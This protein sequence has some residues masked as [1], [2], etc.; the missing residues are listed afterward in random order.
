MVLSEFGRKS[1][2]RRVTDWLAPLPDSSLFVSVVTLGE[3][4]SGIARQRSVD[5]TFSERLAVW[6]AAMR[7]DFEERTLAV[8][9]AVALRW[10][11][12]MTRLRRRDTDLLIA[13]T[14]LEHDLTVVTRNVRH[15]EPAGAR[16]FN[17]YEPA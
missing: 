8:T 14:A 7:D 16:V 17:P 10:G 2:D 4:A 1:A 12:L 9:T 15:F 5:P 6:S 3:I 11:E 13:A